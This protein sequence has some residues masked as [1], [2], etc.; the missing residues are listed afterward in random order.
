VDVFSALDVLEGGKAE[1]QG[2][3][4]LFAALSRS[5]KIPTKVVNGIVYAPP[6]EGFLYHTWAET[7][8]DGTWVAVDPTFGQVSADATHI[9]LVEG[10]TPSDLFP[11]VE[12]MGRISV[13]V[14]EQ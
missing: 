14:L 5:L 10:E 4:F 11:L 9:K 12:L 2:Q 1:C 7:L 3:T 13:R 6:V 8:L